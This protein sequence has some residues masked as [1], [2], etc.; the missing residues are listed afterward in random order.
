MFKHFLQACLAFW[1]L[2]SCV[3]AQSPCAL[4]A[5]PCEIDSGTYHLEL[6][7]DATGP[8]PVMVF[9]H[10]AGGSAEGIMKNRL[11]VETFLEFGYGFLAPDGMRYSATRPGRGWSFHPDREQRRDEV[12][13]L[14]AVLADAAD[15]GDIDR[16]AVVLSGFSIGGSLTWYVACA[17][18]DLAFAYTPIGGAYW[19]AHP[20]PEDCNGPVRLFHMHGWSDRVVPL[21]GRPLGGGR[22]V[23]GDVFAS[24]DIL[25]QVNG[26]DMLRADKTAT[27]DRFWFRRWDSCTSGMELR[28]GL[29]PGGHSVPKGWSRL[30]IEWVDQQR[31]TPVTIQ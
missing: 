10:G 25:R 1:L 18:P 9:L 16:D 8:V 13:F 11:M 17:D 22:I 30:A 6:P 24:F 19:R 2:P 21:E 4:G 3:A 31:N 12:A 23:Q 29:H 5:A 15:R 7:E 27:D 28:L 20:V 14:N 26:C